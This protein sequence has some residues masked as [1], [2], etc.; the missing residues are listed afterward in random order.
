MPTSNIVRSKLSLSSSIPIMSLPES[1]TIPS[2]LFDHYQ[3]YKRS[4]A[5]VLKWLGDNGEITSQSGITVNQLQH[6]AERARAK[7][8]IAPEQVYHAFHD[9]LASRRKVTDWFKS[10]ERNARS[11]PSQSTLNHIHFTEM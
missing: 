10:T 3:K 6:A 5:I 8:I 1:L 7:H 4:T 9:S 11:E 2:A